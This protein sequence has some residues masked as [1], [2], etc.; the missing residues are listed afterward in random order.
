M[1]FRICSTKVAKVFVLSFI[2]AVRSIVAKSLSQL[3]RL[4]FVCAC[5]W[6]TRMTQTWR[7][8]LL[9]TRPSTPPHRMAVV[10]SIDIQSTPPGRWPVAIPTSRPLSPPP[11]AAI[12]HPKAATRSRSNSRLELTTRTDCIYETWSNLINLVQ[13]IRKGRA[14]RLPP[15]HNTISSSNTHKSIQGIQIHDLCFRAEMFFPEHTLQ[16]RKWT[17]NSIFADS[18][19]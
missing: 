8:E 6:S 3:V 14:R 5:C 4:H 17:Q 7:Y 2:V 1:K 16:E 9:R 18:S 15:N 10:F 11:S 19:L 13:L 12:P